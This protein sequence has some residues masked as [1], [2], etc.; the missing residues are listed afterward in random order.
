MTAVSPLEITPSTQRGKSL[1]LPPQTPLCT[2]GIS[3]YYMINFP[4]TYRV[5]T[6]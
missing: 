5:P 6:L 2:C 4:M 1:A 3:L